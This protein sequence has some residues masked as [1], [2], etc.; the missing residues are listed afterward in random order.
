[1]KIVAYNIIKLLLQYPLT[2]KLLLKYLNINIITLKITILEINQKLVEM[3][4]PLIKEKNKIYSLDF[5]KKQRKL[6]YES[7]IDYSREQRYNYLL[8]KI[9]VEKN[10]NL[11]QERHFLNISR[12]TISRDF[13]FIK[14]FLYQKKMI[15]I[16][17]KWKGCYL[18]ILNE[19]NRYEALVEILMIFYSDYNYLPGIIKKYL[20]EIQ[21]KDLDKML[22]KI[23][24]IYDLFNIQIGDFTI[25]YICTL[26]TCIHLSKKFYLKLILNYIRNLEKKLEFRKIYFEVHY[27]QHLNA[28]EALYVSI[29]IY[30]TIYKKFYLEKKFSVVVDKYCEYFHLILSKNEQY[31]L[32]FF[33]H[34]SIFRYNNKIFNVKNVYLEILDLK[35]IKHVKKVFANLNL[36]VLYGDLLEII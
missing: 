33:F 16:T 23:L 8:L 3:K 15:I 25:K 27:N 4:L 30:D 5:S 13:L 14:K 21:P 10:I 17:Q 7:C 12:S 29:I 22:E 2:T 32:T 26:K 6:F 11:E 20:L 24:K 28:T 34:L 1:M 18:E 35:V 31:F 9:L 19:E 36:K